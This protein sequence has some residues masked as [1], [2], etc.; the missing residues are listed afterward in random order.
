MA[1]LVQIVD[2]AM[3]DAVR[4]GGDW[5]ACR[6]GCTTCCLGPFDITTTDAERLRRGLE[7]LDTPAAAA[8]VRRARAYADGEDEPCPALDRSSGL[9]LLYESRPLLCRTFGPATRIGSSIGVCELC[10]QGAP[11]DEIARCAVELEPALFDS[12][13]HLTIAQALALAESV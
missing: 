8:I 1:D 12:A 5:I 3:S 10:F 13:E 2:A 9:C 7:Q 11:D 4:R 6:P